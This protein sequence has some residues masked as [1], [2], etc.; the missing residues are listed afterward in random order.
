MRAILTAKLEEHAL[1]G[2]G[3]NAAGGQI[4]RFPD[5]VWAWFATPLQVGPPPPP[6]GKK[7]GPPQ[8]PWSRTNKHYVQGVHSLERA[9]TTAPPHRYPTYRPRSR[10]M[11]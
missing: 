6:P 1:V 11:I 4:T 2:P 8:P 10:T 9:G 7:A 5:L 3:G